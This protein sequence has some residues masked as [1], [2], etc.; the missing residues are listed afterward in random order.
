MNDP[1]DLSGVWYGHYVSR[2]D[3][4]ANSFIALIEETGGGFD[5][6]ITEPDREG[7]GGIRNA[8]IAGRRTGQALYFVKQYTGRWDHAVRYSGRIDGEGARVS[9]NWNVDGVVGTFTMEREQF[10]VEELEAEEAE[11]LTVGDG[12]ER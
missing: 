6:S 5:G 12:R 1:Q 2:V 10:S 9:G 8:V 3:P 4:Q 7:G 11:E